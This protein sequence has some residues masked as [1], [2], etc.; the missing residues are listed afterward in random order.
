MENVDFIVVGA[1]AAGLS[2]GIYGSRA[3]LKTLIFDAAT[4][5]GQVLQIDNCE[6]YPG[7]FPAQNGASL[8]EKMKNQAMEFG[9]QILLANV[10]SIEK[11][12]DVF[13]VKT[14]TE[15]FCSKALCFATGCEHK[16]LDIF[17]EK[18]FY[19]K[20]VSYCAVC[21]G[22][23]FKN[24]DIVVV[25][26]GD[27]AC[28]EALFLAKLASSV[29]IVH[30]RNVFRA[31]KSLVDRINAN[32]KIKVI[33]DSVVKE[34]KGSSTVESVEIENVNSKLKTELATSG[35]FIFI[36]MQPKTLLV[37]FVQKDLKGYILTDEN[38]QTSVKGLFC[39]GDV[40]SKPLRQVITAASDGAVAAVSAEKYISSLKNVR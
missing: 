8:I 23:F 19:G 21:D 35:V 34:I 3:G 17:G 32:K 27:S 5:G 37:D 29:T 12:D 13:F 14:E 1:G 22:P 25:G 11:K 40:R 7:I 39:A 6:N 4:V 2:A 15:E 9:A 20:G 33:F 36:G 28:S 10:K 16:K 18:E 31:Q 26:G 30:R 38:M 24:K